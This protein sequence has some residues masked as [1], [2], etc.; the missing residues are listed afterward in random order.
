MLRKD[1]RPQCKPDTLAEPL[2]KRDPPAASVCYK[3]HFYVIFLNILVA[4]R[5]KC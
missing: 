3:E 4:T 5:S 2:L 1:N